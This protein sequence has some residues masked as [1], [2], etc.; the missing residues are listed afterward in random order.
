MKTK[1]RK[2]TVKNLRQSGVKVLICHQRVYK[3]PDIS[4]TVNVPKSKKVSDILKPVYP[5]LQAK[6]GETRVVIDMPNGKHYEANTICSKKDHYNKARAVS[7]CLARIA[8]DMTISE[9]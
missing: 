2:L 5:E 6:G 4:Y 8:N 1:P 9:V 3:L 7:I